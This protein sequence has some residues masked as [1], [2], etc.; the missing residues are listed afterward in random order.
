MERLMRKAEELARRYGILY[1]EIRITKV[2]ASHLTMQ[3]SQLEELA[4]NTEIGIGVR[5]FNGAW[6][7]SSANDMSRAERAIE[8]A[9]KIAKLSKGDSRIYLGDPVKD[10]AEIKVKQSFLDV[11]IE[12]KLSLVKEVD[13]LLKGDS[14]SNRS[15]SYGDGLKEQLYFNSLGSEIE[16]VVPR[17]R[18]SFSVTA[19]GNG[20]MQQYW[21]SFGGAAGWELVE[22]VDLTHWTAFVR[23]KAISLLSAKSPPSG[24]FDVIMDPELTGVFIHEALGHAAEADAIKTGESILTGR[25]GERIAVEELTVVDDPTLPG[26]FG[27]YIYDD[28]GIRA[29]RVEIIKN[30]VLLNYLNDRETAAVLGLEPNGHGRAQGYSYQPLVR[31]SNTYV[32]PRDWSFE[33]ILSEV[34]HGLYMIG[35]KGGEVDTA[36]GTFTFGAKEGYIIENGEIKEQVRDVALSGKILDVLKN[37]RAIGSDLVVEFPGYCGKGQWVPV[38]DGGPHVLTRAVVGGL[39]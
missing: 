24:E 3:N 37:I 5:A 31:M 35:D 13:S 10:R 33:E 39:R 20:E 9:M 16:T 17:I 8:T 12:D 28:E 11:D 22:G 23:K 14:I 1:Y 6:G 30:G 7:F 2:T 18:L 36:N 4:L 29:K 27:S 19:K 26:K 25:L 38:D 32:E 15:V 21:K 34:K